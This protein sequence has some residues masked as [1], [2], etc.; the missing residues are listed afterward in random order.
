MAGNRKPGRLGPDGIVRP[1]EDEDKIDAHFAACFSTPAGR[2]VLRH[3]R[4]ITI[5][6]VAGPAITPNE[7]MH[8]E[9]MRFLA[10]IIEQRVERGRHV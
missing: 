8:R 3:L 2:E 1:Q 9:G 6:A 10:A 4:A 7:L 5:E